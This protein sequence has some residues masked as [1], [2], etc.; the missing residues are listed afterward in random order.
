MS[1]MSVLT[2]GCLSF[3]VCCCLFLYSLIYHAGIIPPSNEMNYP[4]TEAVQELLEVS[5]CSDKRVNKN[6]STKVCTLVENLTFNSSQLYGEERVSA[7]LEAGDKI[8][9]IHQRDVGLLH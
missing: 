5:R 1:C 3:C 4:L 2:N 6:R 8:I 7:S 9:Y